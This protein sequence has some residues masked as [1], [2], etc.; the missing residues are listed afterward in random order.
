LYRSNNLSRLLRMAVK[1]SKMIIFE[2]LKNIL[3]ESKLELA[4]ATEKRQ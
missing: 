4:K 3:K 1:F 2:Y